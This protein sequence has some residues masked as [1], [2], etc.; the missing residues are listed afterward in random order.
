MSLRPLFEA[1]D[2]DQDWLGVGGTA[3]LIDELLA[4]R[5]ID[6]VPATYGP[7]PLEYE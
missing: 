6:V 7:A 5:M 3:A 4:N 2:T 1:M